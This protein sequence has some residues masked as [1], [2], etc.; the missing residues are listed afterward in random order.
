MDV[1][2]A[3]HK[4]RTHVADA[5]GEKTETDEAE[6]AQWFAREADDALDGQIE[7]ASCIPFGAPGMANSAIA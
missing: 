6:N 7:Q 4:R 3:C 2:T 5:G 1:E